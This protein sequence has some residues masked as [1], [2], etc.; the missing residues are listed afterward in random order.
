MPVAAVTLRMAQYVES[1]M[2]MLNNLSSATPWGPFTY[3]EVAAA[4]SLP[5]ADTPLPA[6]TDARYEHF[7]DPIPEY[8]PFAQRKQADLDVCR[9][10]RLYVFSGHEVHA[11]DDEELLYVP[12]GHS[13]HPLEPATGA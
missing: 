13:R 2:Y 8:L 11:D 7:D 6:T 3:A 1:T 5:V 9:V 12:T 4:P 10:S